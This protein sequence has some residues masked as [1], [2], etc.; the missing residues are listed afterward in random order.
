MR[1]LPPVEEEIRR[2]ARDERAKDPLITVSGLERTLEKHFNRGFS[3]QYVS[4]IA[5]KVAREA[6]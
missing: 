6:L 2:V 4:K 3:H 1:I 5:D